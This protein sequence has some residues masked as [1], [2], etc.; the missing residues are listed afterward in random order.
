VNYADL[1]QRFQTLRNLGEAPSLIS[2][3]SDFSIPA[4][5]NESFLG[6]AAGSLPLIKVPSISFKGISVKNLSASKIDFGIT[7]E[8]ENN[9]SFALSIKDLSY[10]IAVN[11]TQWAGGRASG[12]PQIAANRKTEIPLTISINSLSLV[13]DLTDIITRGTDVA[14][15]CGGNINLGAALSG[16][17]DFGTPFNF[18]GTTKL[19]R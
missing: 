10:N 6:E 12:T 7:W 13:R 5:A 17:D 11:N 16:L 14:Y 15:V 3:K 2:L 9:N 1:Y 19:R 4:F 8:V 18:T